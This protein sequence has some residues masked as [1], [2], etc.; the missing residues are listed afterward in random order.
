MSPL[1]KREILVY[2]TLKVMT[3]QEQTYACSQRHCVGRRTE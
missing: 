1:D 3:E 2:T